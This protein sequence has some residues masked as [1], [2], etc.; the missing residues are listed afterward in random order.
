MSEVVRIDSSENQWTKESGQLDIRPAD[1]LAD[2][3]PRG[4]FEPTPARSAEFALNVSE[5]FIVDRVENSTGEAQGMGVAQG[6]GEAQGVGVAQDSG[7]SESV[8]RTTLSFTLIPRT[9]IPL[10]LMPQ[11]PL[12]LMLS[13]LLTISVSMC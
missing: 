3:G 11:M 7:V 10:T 13:S 1:E 12:T 6:M 5:S 2:P 9:Q 8:G 4:T